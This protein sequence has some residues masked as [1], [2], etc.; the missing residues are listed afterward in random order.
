M[1]FRVLIVD[2]EPLARERLAHFLAAEPDMQVMGEAGHGKEALAILEK[3]RP[4][5]MLLDVQ[6]PG[7]SGLDVLRALGP[8]AMPPT[9]FVTAY[10]QHALEA[11]ELCA[12]DYLLKPCERTRF[13][14]SLDRIRRLRGTGQERDFQSQLEVLL[15][16]LRTGP[17]HLERLFVRVGDAQRLLRVQDIRWIE[18]QD[19][20]V[21]LHLA[22]EAH[23]LRQTL[24]SLEARLDPRRFRRIHRS[25][26]V[27]LDHVKEVQPWF[28]GELAAVLQDGTTLAVSRSYRGGFQE[29]G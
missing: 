10:D 21:R 18:A 14:A 4:D 5:L 12:Q 8:L 20:Y 27:N 9:I 19:N 1:T 24:S 17:P 3:A 28:N 11:F 25:T 7:M 13:Q 23:L 26:L 6:M 16:T 2:D 15:A 29:L 22:D